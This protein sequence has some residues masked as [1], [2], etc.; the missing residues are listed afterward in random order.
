MFADEGVLGVGAFGLGLMNGAIGFGG[1]IGAIALASRGEFRS[2]GWILLGSL[3]LAGV[4]FALFSQSKVF[5]LSVI[6]MGGEGFVSSTYHVTLFVLLLQSVPDEMRGRVIG[7]WGIALGT[8]PSNGGPTCYLAQRIGP[9]FAAGVS[10][11]TL[12]VIAILVAVAIPQLRR[13]Q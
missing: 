1:M 7:V 10:G 5:A 13:L 12:T 4:F 2:K 11:A 6:L 3:I 8:G 9:E